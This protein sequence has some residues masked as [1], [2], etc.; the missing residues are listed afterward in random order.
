[1]QGR[2]L[3]SVSRTSSNMSRVDSSMS[4]HKNTELP[5]LASATINLV[6]RVCLPGS[7]PA[8]STAAAGV[9]SGKDLK[10][11]SVKDA[12]GSAGCIVE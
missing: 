4:G 1:M 12:L 9:R 10:Q 5:A 8:D 7:H 11:P 3:I 6:L 2:A